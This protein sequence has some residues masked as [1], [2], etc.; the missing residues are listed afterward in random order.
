MG[1][2]KSRAVHWKVLVLCVLSA[3][4]NA[5]CGAL[6]SGVL[7]LSLYLDTVFTVAV[8]F[9]FGLLPGLL[10]GALLYP[11]Y[12]ILRNIILNTGADTFWAVNAF[13]LCTVSEILLVSIFRSGIVP[14]PGRDTGGLPKR[15]RRFVPLGESFLFSFIGIAAQLMVLAALDCVVVSITGGLVDFV[16]H[17]LPASPGGT[18]PEDIFKLSLF[19]NNVPYL[20]SAILSRI[21]INI[22]DRFIAVFAGYGISLLYRAWAAP[23]FPVI[24]GGR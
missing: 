8:T 21:P 14:A 3:F 10:T 9:S 12:N 13:I 16:L 22:V 15:P 7:G 19:R 23:R 1:N 2:G 20:A 17:T 6:V 18:Y 5:A 4:G 11:G 24:P